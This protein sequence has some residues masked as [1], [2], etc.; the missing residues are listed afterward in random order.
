M[1]CYEDGFNFFIFMNEITERLYQSRAVAKECRTHGKLKS[2][3]K[4]SD[5]SNLQNIH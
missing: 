2:N 4:N 3:V 5:V 1:A